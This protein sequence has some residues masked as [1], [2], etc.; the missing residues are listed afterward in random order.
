MSKVAPVAYVDILEGDVEGHVRFH[1]PEDATA[2]SNA[3]EQ[4]L[5]EHGWKLEIL[6]G[7][8]VLT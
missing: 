5:R 7:S 4:L 3:K 2:I 1:S 8:K 6:K